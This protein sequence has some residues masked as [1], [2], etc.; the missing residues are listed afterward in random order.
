HDDPNDETKA[1]S[2]SPRSK[3]LRHWEKGD[4]YR[5]IYQLS[6]P[7]TQVLGSPFSTP[8]STPVAGASARCH[9]RLGLGVPLR[10][11]SRGAG[12]NLRS[13]WSAPGG[14]P[15]RRD[16][17]RPDGSLPACRW[18]AGPRL[19]RGG[20]S[21][22]PLAPLAVQAGGRSLFNNA[23]AGGA[24]VSGGDPAGPGLGSGLNRGAVCA[25]AVRSISAEG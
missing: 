11:D 6:R 23:G 17:Y 24:P 7:R 1:P 8:V 9:G 19:D 25:P 18:L 12:S 4:R 3:T 22:L 20:R 16:D 15:G 21:C 14:L 10:R 13:P 5:R 2:S